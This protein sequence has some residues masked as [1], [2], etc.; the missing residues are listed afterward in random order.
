MEINSRAEFLNLAGLVE[1]GTILA[2]LAGGWLLGISPWESMP[3]QWEA[4]GLGLLATLPMLG[5]FFIATGPRTVATE[6]LGAALSQCRWYD[7][8]LLAALAGV[9]EELL[10]RGVLQPWLALWHPTWAFVL[11]NI[12]FGLLHAVTPTYALLAVGVGMIGM[13]VVTTILVFLLQR[14]GPR[15]GE[16]NSHQQVE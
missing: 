13:S 16:K 8:I 14:F 15:H 4:A 5:L 10:F 3:W 12:A 11:T 7:L 2:A 9:G 1:G 6:L